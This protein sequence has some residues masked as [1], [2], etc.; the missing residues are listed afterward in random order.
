MDSRLTPLLRNETPMFRVWFLESG[1]LE[2]LLHIGN[3]FLELPLSRILIAEELNKQVS[4]YLTS[5]ISGTKL[6]QAMQIMASKEYCVCKVPKYGGDDAARRLNRNEVISEVITD[7]QRTEQQ[8][9]AISKKRRKEKRVEK[10][11]QKKIVRGSG[12]VTQEKS[13]FLATQAH[14]IQV[15]VFSADDLSRPCSAIC[16]VLINAQKFSTPPTAG[17]TTCP[18]FNGESMLFGINSLMNERMKL[19]INDAALPSPASFMGEV[20]VPL[21]QLLVSST[22]NAVFPLTARPGVPVSGS[23]HVELEYIANDRTAAPQKLTKKQIELFCSAQPYRVFVSV[24][25]VEGLSF[26]AGVEPQAVVAYNRQVRK[27]SVRKSPQNLHWRE[28][29]LPFG[30]FDLPEEEVQIALVDGRKRT[31]RST[32][33]IL[34]T[35]HAPIDILQTNTSFSDWFPLLDPVTGD[36]IPSARAKVTF[37]YVTDGSWTT[38]SAGRL[39]FRPAPLLYLSI[40]CVYPRT[41]MF[42]ND[43]LPITIKIRDLTCGKALTNNLY[44]GILETRFI[45][46]SKKAFYLPAHQNYPD[47]SEGVFQV[48]FV[49]TEVGQYEA[50]IFYRDQP[51]QHRTCIIKVRSRNRSHQVSISAK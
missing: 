47:P 3:T 12:L 36:V 48:D 22:W 49:P 23:I 25:A 41:K 9:A 32:K 10:Q 11:L 43:T 21:E 14:R 2:D 5:S 42:I 50:M 44:G 24:V 28:E 38:E 51:M 39:V 29:R 37:E 7:M 13:R 34:A 35:L 27:T 17:I 1:E 6:S 46:P 30:V 18:D 40:S 26:G 19:S 16:S 8:V 33:P 20:E 45:P 15:T 31:V 4:Q